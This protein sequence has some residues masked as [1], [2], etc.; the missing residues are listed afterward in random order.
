MISFIC[1]PDRSSGEVRAKQIAPFIEGAEVLHIGHLQVPKNKYV[2]FVRQFDPEYCRKLHSMGFIVGRDIADVPAWDF[3]LERTT[4]LKD[5][6][7]PECSFYIVNNAWYK[8]QVEDLGAKNVFVIPHHSCNFENERSCTGER[9]KTVGYVG[10]PDQ[11]SRAKDL[12]IFCS[13]LG[14]QFKSVN[15]TTRRDLVDQLKSID[16]GLIFLDETTISNEKIEYTKKFKPNVKLTNFQSYGIPTICL[17]YESYR[18]FG[19]EAYLACSNYEDLIQSIKLIL[20]DENLRK[21]LS[22]DGI[23]ASRF[24]SIKEIVKMYVT[25]IQK[26]HL[27][28]SS[29][30]G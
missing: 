4:S 9:L 10:L 13:G 22:N 14:L 24:L 6:I 30:Q 23:E 21:K 3:R 17:E 1:L 29:V 8:R 26:V 18:E 12:E 28:L 27:S 2:I 16:L 15:P 11:I 19:R 25:M 20:Q 5:Y 7:L